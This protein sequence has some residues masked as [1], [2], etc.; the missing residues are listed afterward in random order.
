MRIKIYKYNRPLLIITSLLCILGLGIL[1]SSALGE[2][3]S[4]SNFVRIMV[5]QVAGLILGYAVILIAIAGKKIDYRDLYKKHYSL[6]FFLGAII[7]QL[8]VF[9]PLGV[10]RKG[11]LRWI[12]IG[13]T[14]VQP[15]EF[16]KIAMVLFLAAMLVGFKKE[17]KNFF[18]LTTIL[19]ISVGLVAVIMLLIRD[20]GTLI[21]M[22]ISVTCML[23]LSRARKIHVII[24]IILGFISLAS[25][26]TLYDKEDYAR[27]RILSYLGISQS[28]QGQDYQVNQAIATI[29][30]GQ[31]LGK[32]Y[33]QSI[34][35][36][37]YLPETINDSIFAV[38]AEEW[39]FVGSVFLIGL[40]LA[41][42]WIGFT[43]AR[44]SKD[45]YGRYVAIGLTSLVTAQA[46]F[47]MMALVK[48]VPLSGMPLIFIS[49]GGSSI[50]ASLVM[51][52]I[53]LNISRH[54]IR[55]TK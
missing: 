4:T 16:L 49:K 8:L 3:D 7:F 9:S 53:L 11:A 37:S 24:L 46:L 39:G 1:F 14:T 35:K 41:F 19:A 36:Y 21:I 29:G 13:I 55:V 28:P 22:G 51:V 6:Y 20:K 54:N 23:F 34:Q 10:S 26:V 25:F 12:D 15:S 48:L 47:N 30:S 5:V 31:I 50:L 44:R 38:Y 45:D 52:A 27:S 43:I 17:I 18:S 33:G 40:F 2:L 42:T 32:G